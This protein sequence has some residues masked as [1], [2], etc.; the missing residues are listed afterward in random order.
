MQRS[1]QDTFGDLVQRH[2]IEICCR[3]LAKRSFTYTLPRGFLESLYRDLVRRSCREISYR[4]LGQ[5]SCQ[6]TDICAERALIEILYRDLARRPPMEILY[7]DL[8]K[9]AEVLLGD[10]L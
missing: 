6:E 9:R 5:R 1:F 7:G 8:V 10:H 2:C 4:Y 3:D